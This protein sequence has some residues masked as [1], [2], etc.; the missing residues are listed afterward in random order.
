MDHTIQR[1]LQELNGVS[2]DVFK[3]QIASLLA[4]L[5]E[6]RSEDL[7]SVP[8]DGFVSIAEAAFAKGELAL[9]QQ[10]LG[11]YFKARPPTSELH[12]SSLMLLC[13]TL[14]PKTANDVKILEELVATIISSIEMAASLDKQHPKI[15]TATN[16]FCTA[17]YP[18]QVSSHQETLVEGATKILGMLE[19]GEWRRKELL[20]LYRAY[21]AIGFILLSAHCTGSRKNASASLAKKLFQAA[22]SAKQSDDMARLVFIAVQHSIVSTNSVIKLCGKSMYLHLH[23][24]LAK[25]IRYDTEHHEPSESLAM[26]LKVLSSSAP[27]MVETDLFS[28]ARRHLRMESSERFEALSDEQRHRLAVRFSETAVAQGLHEQALRCVDSLGD[29]NDMTPDVYAKAEV[30][31]IKSSQAKCFQDGDVQGHVNLVKSAANLIAT[32]QVKSVEFLEVVSQLLWTSAVIAVKA[33]ERTRLRLQLAVTANALD[34]ANSNKVVLRCNLHQEAALGAEDFD[35]ESAALHWQKASQLDL[36]GYNK[37]RIDYNARRIK[38]LQER[39][40]EHPDPMDRI[41]INIEKVINPKKANMEPDETV[42]ECLNTA[43]SLLSGDEKVIVQ[44]LELAAGRA[45]PT[46][47]DIA[48]SST[49]L[50]ALRSVSTA[51]IGGKARL[52][53]VHCDAVKQHLHL[54]TVH[55]N[56]HQRCLEATEK[57]V[58]TAKDADIRL[59]DIIERARLWLHLLTAASGSGNAVLSRVVGRFADRCADSDFLAAAGITDRSTTASGS[60]SGAS[61][62]AKDMQ[63]PSCFKHMLQEVTYK[64]LDHAEALIQELAQD[65]IGLFEIP[66]QPLAVRT[67]IAD[68]VDQAIQAEKAALRQEARTKREKLIEDKRIEYEAALDA[69]EKLEEADEATESHKEF[70]SKKTLATPPAVKECTLPP[71]PEP[72][73]PPPEVVDFPVS[74]ERQQSMLEN[75]EYNKNWNVFL[76]HVQRVNDELHQIFMKCLNISL[77]LEDH[78][79]LNTCIRRMLQQLV[80]HRNIQYNNGLVLDLEFWKL[81]DSFPSLIS[82]GKYVTTVLET[83]LA[84]RANSA[85]SGE[86]TARLCELSLLATLVQCMPM[87]PAPPLPPEEDKKGKDKKK[88]KKPSV[89]KPGSPTNIRRYLVTSPSHDVF[90]RKQ[91]DLCNSVLSSKLLQ[92]D[93]SPRTQNQIMEYRCCVSQLLLQLGSKDSTEV[94][95][96]S[97]A[98]NMA[99]CQVVNGL[100]MLHMNLLPL[101]KKFGGIDDLNK[102]AEQ[103]SAV[104]GSVNDAELLFRL[105]YKVMEVAFE[106][107]KLHKLIDEQLKLAYRV[108]HSQP[109]STLSQQQVEA[110][111]NIAHLLS[112]MHLLCGK[113]HLVEK[114]K[115]IGSPDQSAKTRL[116]CLHVVA[117]QF[118]E[119]AMNADRVGDYRTLMAVAQAFFCGP[120]GELLS[121][122][123]FHKRAAAATASQAKRDTST[124]SG[125]LAGTY[126]EVLD[127]VH[128]M[129]VWISKHAARWER[130]EK[131]NGG[132]GR[133]GGS[134]G[135]AQLSAQSNQSATAAAG[136]TADA[137]ASVPAAAPMSIKDSHFML[138]AGLLEVE[139]KWLLHRRQHAEGLKLS[140]RALRQIPRE[141]QRS[142]DVYHLRFRMMTTDFDDTEI[143]KLENPRDRYRL[144]QEVT[145]AATD[146]IRIQNAFEQMLKIIQNGEDRMEYIY[147]LLDY[148][149]WM[150]ENDYQVTDIEPLLDEVK[151]SV[152]ALPPVEEPFQLPSPCDNAIQEEAEVPDKKSRKSPGPGSRAKSSRSRASATPQASKAEDFKIQTD[153]NKLPATERVVCLAEA[154]ALSAKIYLNCEPTN[155]GH[156]HVRK[157]TLAAAKLYCHIWSLATDQAAL[158]I[159]FCKFLED[160]GPAASDAKAKAKAKPKKKSPSPAVGAAVDEP[161]SFPLP[162]TPANWCTYNLPDKAHEIVGPGS[163]LPGAINTKTI[164]NV[165]RTLECLRSVEDCLSRIGLLPLIC[166][167]LALEK[168]INSWYRDSDYSTFIQLRT[169]DVACKLELNTVIP[170]LT[171]GN[172]FPT[173]VQVHEFTHL[174]L[175]THLGKIREQEVEPSSPPSTA[176]RSWA[177]WAMILCRMGC[178][179]KAL[180]IALIVEPIAREIGDKATLTVVNLVLA[181]VYLRLRQFDKA[182]EIAKGA[183]KITPLESP[184]ICDL[185][186]VL[187]EAICSL[188]GD[189]QVKE[190]TC[191]NTL[192]KLKQ[193]FQKLQSTACRYKFN[194]M[195]NLAVMRLRIVQTRLSGIGQQVTATE[196]DFQ[197]LADLHEIFLSVGGVEE[198]AE[199][200]E[201]A[202]KSWMSKTCINNEIRWDFVLKAYCCGQRAVS[203]LWAHRT[204]VVDEVKFLPYLC[205][206]GSYYTL[207][208]ERGYAKAILSLRQPL[209]P[210]VDDYVSKRRH[211]SDWWTSL[212]DMEKRVETYCLDPEKDA[213]KAS[214]DSPDVARFKNFQQ[215]CIQRCLAAI[216]DTLNRVPDSSPL[217]AKVMEWKGSFLLMLCDGGF[218][219]SLNILHEQFQAEFARR[220]KVKNADEG[221]EFEPDDEQFDDLDNPFGA[222]EPQRASDLPEKSIGFS[223]TGTDIDPN[224]EDHI[225]DDID[226][227]FDDEDNVFESNARVAGQANGDGVFAQPGR[228]RRDQT[229]VR[230]YVGVELMSQLTSDHDRRVEGVKNLSTVV[231]RALDDSHWTL[232]ASAYWDLFKV[233]SEEP[234]IAVHY[235]AAYQSC[236]S[237]TWLAQLLET[238]S[239][240]YT[241]TDLSYMAASLWQRRLVQDCRAVS[242]HVVPDAVRVSEV[243]RPLSRI[244]E[245]FL[246]TQQVSSGL[247][248]SKNPLWQIMD[249]PPNFTFIILQHSPDKSTLHSAVV[250]G[251]MTIKDGA[252]EDDSEAKRPGKKSKEDKPTFPEIAL[253]KADVQSGALSRLETK[254]SGF[255]DLLA[256][257]QLKNE[258]SVPS[259]DVSSG[260]DL[261]IDDATKAEFSEIVHMLQDYVGPC[262]EQMEEALKCLHHPEPDQDEETARNATPGRDAGK[263]KDK[264]P[265]K[266]AQKKPGKGGKE[267]DSQAEP[268][269]RYVVLL[270][271]EDLMS[272]PLEAMPW[273]QANGVEGISRDFS[274][275]SLH[276]RMLHVCPPPTPSAEGTTS[277]AKKGKTT[278][279]VVDPDEQRPNYESTDNPVINC[280]NFHCVIDPAGNLPSK[281][282][283]THVT[284]DKLAKVVSDCGS[285]ASKWVSHMPPP[286]HESYNPSLWDD[287]ASS[288]GGLV[289]FDCG[290]LD[291]HYRVEQLLRHNLTGCKLAILLDKVETKRSVKYM[292]LRDIKER[293]ASQSTDYVGLWSLAGAGSVLQ[294]CLPCSP[295]DNAL[296]MHN[297][298]HGM[299]VQ[300]PKSIGRALLDSRAKLGKD[301]DEV[302]VNTDEATHVQ[303]MPRLAVRSEERMPGSPAYTEYAAPRVFTASSQDDSRPDSALSSDRVAPDGSFPVIPVKPYNYLLWGLPHLAVAGKNQKSGRSK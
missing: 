297:V 287:V 42:E 195:W 119:A 105:R 178:L 199:C 253:C 260:A 204:G 137:Q 125:D 68:D 74:Q 154:H 262:F 270:V 197:E 213:A 202:L 127:I 301:D 1:S 180:D 28:E 117:K 239:R 131:A 48:G 236:S 135:I 33:G 165:P 56:R 87:V 225:A 298:L 4:R 108:Q 104:E 49:G 284:A 23:A 142:F 273:L 78:D 243:Y 167:L 155:S 53:Q 148:S 224:V 207:P 237:L 9:A 11:E 25:T 181:Q 90:L 130:E 43:V 188:P 240:S 88:A 299:C 282:L 268:E 152:L 198:A 59:E 191:L 118:Q 76:G 281:T 5:L 210:V 249:F 113:Y 51:M 112:R 52:S 296:A 172:E 96:M 235:L 45:S 277:Q 85:I 174:K 263:K 242:G 255:F 14:Q 192:A 201:L 147:L 84:A 300:N 24:E 2:L 193:L 97:K 219:P 16:L 95:A 57:A 208:C 184:H 221:A 266:P 82:I 26:A 72:F 279:T 151:A 215:T 21:I 226:F 110:S 245:E 100:S 149:R 217:F 54:C 93:V 272:F 64:L 145:Q 190:K 120:A 214:R 175:R 265:E 168:Y 150:F 41:R 92:C 13:Q 89:V 12:L 157:D 238:A 231:S 289:C 79:M 285:V 146:R 6:K 94:P 101:E 27:H 134:T 107:P 271:D 77:C 176:Y 171:E 122:E 290:P 15:A 222:Q 250:H 37:P 205:G 209:T 34:K 278:T 248:I 244:N 295:E 164:K 22:K 31:R 115:L 232:A 288:C 283:Q 228:S 133:F 124:D 121:S 189:L 20:P 67:L 179:H 123:A 247:S 196:L 162:A 60:H 81:K 75:S 3:G 102:I 46:K 83:L 106:D 203:L 114:S 73:E 65:G 66:A 17:T 256:I 140:E 251:G 293:R 223:S 177:E 111:E 159:A 294:N 291:Q 185:A 29:R 156:E 158:Q 218:P 229:P 61:R 91:I 286:L 71:K 8:V 70:I 50:K 98:F 212:T 103:L 254:W 160:A 211:D 32:G 258:Q 234:F 116:E 35:L 128:L 186:T 182:L 227:Y 241:R 267:D 144:W 170:T 10:S 194:H 166:P 132:P 275:N 276:Q 169:L 38:L 257:K 303:S 161:L 136:N 153:N 173:N 269:S 138:R 143:E 141:F 30:L 40:K 183:L 200:C 280:A 220:K 139:L 292:K 233:F 274:S 187:V 246:A 44:W 62:I 39:Y 126:L 55:A 216:Q 230:L 264:S 259:A 252:K 7:T 261:L 206:E 18:F 80:K 163:A 63:V 86:S 58:L 302:K 36:T 109:Q 129:S 99:L 47:S 69:W 19:M